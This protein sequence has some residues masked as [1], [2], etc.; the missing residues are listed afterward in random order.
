MKDQFWGGGL[1]FGC[2]FHRWEYIWNGPIDMGEFF[3]N[4]IQIDFS[5]FATLY[6]HI[7]DETGGVFHF[8]SLFLNPTKTFWSPVS[9]GG[10]AI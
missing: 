5:H 9:G 8:P 4:Q 2:R 3:L 6:F 10:G 7:L 1:F